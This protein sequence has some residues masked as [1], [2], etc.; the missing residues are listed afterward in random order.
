MMSRRTKLGAMVSVLTAGLFS[1]ACAA[2]VP[3]HQALAGR[4]GGFLAVGSAG[5]RLVLEIIADQPVVMYSPDQG[6]ARIPATKGR[7]TAT[8]VDVEFGAVRAKLKVALNPA[9]HLVG[10]FQQGAARPIEFTRLAAGEEPARPVAGPFG[11]L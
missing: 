9:G 10:Q 8:E 7:C 2:D 3:G 11:D 1:S 4:W 5:L 6:N